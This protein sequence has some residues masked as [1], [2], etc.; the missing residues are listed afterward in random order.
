MRC[1]IHEFQDALGNCESCGQP[2]CNDCTERRDGKF[3]CPNCRGSGWLESEST[4]STSSSE[5][6]YPEALVDTKSK[7]GLFTIAGFGALIG[8]LGYSLNLFLPVFAFG[9]FDM[10]S[11]FIMSLVGAGCSILAS[12]L[13][14]VGFYGFYVNYENKI[15]LLAA[16]LQI[17]SIIVS[18]IYLAVLG[19]V[20]YGLGTTGFE[21]QQT[22][23]VNILFIM[24]LASLVPII[25]SLMMGISLY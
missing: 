21:M 25:T 7:S 16:F 15:G 10:A 23:F 18:M 20:L 19:P 12:V 22:D 11:V 6:Q 9:V 24:L 5:K 1:Y 13:V 4:P 2:I 17:I 3:Y 8:I 14:S